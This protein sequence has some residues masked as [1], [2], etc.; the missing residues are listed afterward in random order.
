MSGAALVPLDP[1]L[2]AYAEAGMPEG[3]FPLATQRAV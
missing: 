1:D 2:L 3:V